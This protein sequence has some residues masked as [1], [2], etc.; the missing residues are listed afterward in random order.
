MEQANY[1]FCIHHIPPDEWTGGQIRLASVSLW[2][3]W[4]TFCKYFPFYLTSQLSKFTLRRRPKIKLLL[5]FGLILEPKDKTYL[6]N[7]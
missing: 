1:Y 3:Y 4:N 5:V 7:G 6:V 2:V